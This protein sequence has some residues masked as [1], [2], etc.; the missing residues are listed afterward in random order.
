MDCIVTVIYY[1]LLTVTMYGVVNDE[2]LS[3]DKQVFVAVSLCFWTVQ[4]S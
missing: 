4:V 2:L 1:H 3:W